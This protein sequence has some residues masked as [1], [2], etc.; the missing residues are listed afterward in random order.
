MIKRANKVTALLI[1]ATSVISSVS[2]AMATDRLD[3]KDGSI[4]NAVAFKDGKY[5]YEGSKDDNATGVY[6]NDGTNDKL[7]DNVEDIDSSPKFGSS[8]A[9]VSHGSNEYEVN[10]SDGTV[11]DDANKDDLES[12]AK[13]K[14]GTKLEGTARYGSNTEIKSFNRVSDGQFGDDWYEYTATGD[15]AHANITTD[16]TGTTDASVYVED[17]WSNEFDYESRIEIDIT[18]LWSNFKIDGKEFDQGVP[19]TWINVSKIK[20]K[21]LSA[22]FDNY[23]VGQVAR[24]ANTDGSYHIKFTLLPKVGV[25]I[26]TSLPDDFITTG[27]GKKWTKPTWGFTVTPKKSAL[28]DAI[29]AATTNSNS[30]EVSTDGS[31][32]LVASKWVTA[33][34]KKTYTDAIAAAQAIA[35]KTECTKT[36]GDNA[37]EALA[38]ATTAFNTAE[39]AGTKQAQTRITVKIDSIWGTISIAGVNFSAKWGSSNLMTSL[40]SDIQAAT[41]SGYTLES[42][43]SDE[44]T[45]TAIFTTT[46]ELSS[47][48]AGFTTGLDW[49]NGHADVSLEKINTVAASVDK[50]GLQTLYDS[51]KNDTQGSYTN[52]SWS[53]FTTALNNAETVINDNAATQDEVDTAKTDLNNAVS[54]L[55]NSSTTTGAAVSVDKSALKALYDSHKNDTQGSYTNA[56]WS[57]FTTALNNAETVINNNAATQNQVDTSKT[58]LNDAVNGLVSPKTRITVNVTSLW[59]NIS[60]AGINFSARWGSS[61]LMTSLAADIK[62]AS[63]TGYTLE[64][65]TSDGATVTAIFTTTDELSSVPA[66]FTK[67]LDWSNGYAN[68]SIEPITTSIS[69]TTDTTTGA[70][71]S[72]T[73][74][75]VVNAENTNNATETIIQN[76]NGDVYAAVTTTSDSVV[77]YG[78][79][80][81]NGN[82]IDCSKI[83]NISVYDGTHVVKIDN[84]NEET[85][86][87]G[88]T[89]KLGLPTLV[90]TLGQDKDYIYSVISVPVTGYQTVNGTNYTDTA[91]ATVYYVQK[92]SKARGK[93][94]DG[95]YLP[96]T[97][98]SYELDNYDGYIDNNWSYG[99]AYSA[100]VPDDSSRKIKIIDGAIYVAYK[101]QDSNKNDIVEVA[102][103]TLSKSDRIG[104]YDDANKHKVTVPLVTNPTSASIELCPWTMDSNG[105][106]WAIDDGVI[107]KSAQAN[108][109]QDM[110]SCDKSIDNLD[111]YDDTNLIGWSSNS[112]KY[113]TV[114]DGETAATSSDASS[115]ANSKTRI[116]VKVTNLWGDITIAGV[117]FS[118]KW[119]G[120]LMA[121]LAADIKAASFSG[122]TLESA[123]SDG[124]AVTVTFI[125][126]GKLSAAPAGF[127][128]G[129]DWSSGYADVSVA[130][131]TGTTIGAAATNTNTDAGAV[132][133]TGWQKTD[134]GTWNYMDD[135]G[136]MKTGWIKVDGNWYYLDQSGTMQANTIVDGYSLDSNGVWIQYLSNV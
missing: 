14:L 112:N 126:P 125:A 47:V 13:S 1:A 69:T 91:T 59:G 29:T 121:S 17:T 64:S 83:A 8:Y 95:A 11:S 60:I 106:V 18:S 110:Y 4:T 12:A 49:S 101:S 116:T 86:A 67:G 109:F 26:P 15:P 39:A 37:V 42:V 130:D 73:T 105:N 80:D 54:G 135:K 34:V 63:F 120:D 88:K 131:A 24:L 71:A 127:T 97:V 44:K 35:D 30:V 16:N 117:K 48:P 33:A 52:A 7:L 87:D 114:K 58:N 82:Y 46:D 77:Y 123:T 38:A 66:G 128:K 132:T 27:S 98:E 31:D 23:E 50:S 119:G 81:D 90:R 113:I 75:G 102:K 78:Y 45:V 133:K 2:P 108:S 21:L 40:A 107:K 62:A 19:N 10:L 84:F 41:F 22:N 70:A 100:V 36:E 68:V 53:T 43:T 111:V 136:V 122:Y 129:L 9:S 124:K 104:S 6:Y 76:L 85:S 65:V 56:S 51:H 61:N 3:A 72:V 5:L 99:D 94:E 93:R 96:N 89:V 28:I 115:D 57:T 118:P 79:T 103:L 134:N 25:T 32:V 92:I 55:V 74:S 20:D